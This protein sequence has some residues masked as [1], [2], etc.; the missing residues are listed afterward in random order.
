M[1]RSHSLEEV[2]AAHLPPEWTDSVRWLRRRLNSG[3][4]T[5]FKVGRSW[6]MTD[7]DVENL[8]RRWRNAE[9]T[10]PAEVPAAPLVDSE[11]LTFWEG[12]S[13]GSRRRLRSAS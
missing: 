11:D 7:E 4:L 1:K 5:G 2:A 10:T 3:E 9:P 12:L 6:R 8:T 13:E